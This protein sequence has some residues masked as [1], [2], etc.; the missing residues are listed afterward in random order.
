VV[1]GAED[2]LALAQEAQ[3]L[4]GEPDAEQVPVVAADAVERDH[5]ISPFL[6]RKSGPQ[7][8]SLRRD[9]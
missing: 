1:E 9:G 7:V 6:C 2:R 3:V 4:F 5:V 8:A